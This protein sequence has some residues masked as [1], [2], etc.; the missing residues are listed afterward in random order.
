M[1]QLSAIIEAWLKNGVRGVYDVHARGYLVL[2]LIGGAALSTRGAGDP[3][4]VRSIVWGIVLLVLSATVFAAW[5][6]R[7]P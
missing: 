5:T 1:R 7:G 6:H 2:G 3:W 4:I